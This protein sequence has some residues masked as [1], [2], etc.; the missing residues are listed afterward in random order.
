VS[1]NAFRP[2][3]F[4]PEMAL[5]GAAFLQDASVQERTIRVQLRWRAISAPRSDYEAAVHLL[6][7]AGNVRA[8]SHETLLV[9][10]RSWPTSSWSVGQDIEATYTLDL[11][12]DL[13]PDRYQIAVGLA[14]AGTGAWASV[15]GGTHTSRGMAV[16]VLSIDIPL[17]AA[18]RP[19]SLP[20]LARPADR[21]AGSLVP[22]DRDLLSTKG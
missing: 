1:E 16:T 13:S 19:I 3:H 14:D 5:A 4:G 17:P 22:N 21:G 9:D 2:I 11:P 8:T 20:W 6:D 18:A 12:P 7:K 10:R 15:I